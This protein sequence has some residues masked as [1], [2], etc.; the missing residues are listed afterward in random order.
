MTKGDEA[1]VG[2]F[3]VVEILTSLRRGTHGGPK[4]AVV[5]A[6]LPSV[7]V[8]GVIGLGGWWR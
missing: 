1:S 3:V 8:S 2:S 5:H 6:R 4:R 7:Q